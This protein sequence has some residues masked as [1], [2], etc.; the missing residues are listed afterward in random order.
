MGDLYLL[1]SPKR[2]IKWTLT[3]GQTLYSADQNKPKFLTGLD[4]VRGTWGGKK[5]GWGVLLPFLGLGKAERRVS[6]TFIHCFSH[7]PDLYLT[8]DC[9]VFINNGYFDNHYIVNHAKVVKP[10]CFC[11][12]YHHSACFGFSPH[13]PITPDFPHPGFVYFCC[14]VL[15]CFLLLFCNSLQLL[16]VPHL[17]R[18]QTPTGLVAPTFILCPHFLSQGPALDRFPDCQLGNSGLGHLL[19]QPSP[20]AEASWHKLF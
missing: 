17:T 7:L 2:S 12:C 20:L 19:L 16:S 6:W 11:C 14:F 3:Q 10:P 9:R 4:G 18:L 5:K 13:R 15:F 1:C 8:V